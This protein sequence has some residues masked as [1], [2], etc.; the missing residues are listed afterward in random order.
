MQMITNS[1]QPTYPKIDYAVNGIMTAKFVQDFGMIQKKENRIYDY[2]CVYYS[3][4]DK[5]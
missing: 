4:E 3:F 2:L 1:E 5:K